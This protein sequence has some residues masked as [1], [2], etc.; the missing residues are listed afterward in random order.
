MKQ[1]RTVNAS[2]YVIFQELSFVTIESGFGGK[3]AKRMYMSVLLPGFVTVFYSMVKR[4]HNVIKKRPGG[5]HFI[6]FSQNEN[7][8]HKY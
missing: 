2:T 1:Q 7:I 8:L 3:R 4:S 6:L 5:K